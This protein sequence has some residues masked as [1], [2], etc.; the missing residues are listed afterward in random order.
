MLDKSDIPLTNEERM[1]Q[2]EQMLYDKWKDR[3][4]TSKQKR[5]LRKLGIP[6]ENDLSMAQGFFL[7][8][9]KVNQVD[10]PEKLFQTSM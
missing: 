2:I 1:K 3:P 4:A 5:Y 9:Q 7:I 6:F 10:F 8:R